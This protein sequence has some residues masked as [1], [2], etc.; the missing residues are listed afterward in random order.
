[1]WNVRIGAGDVWIGVD[2]FD[3]VHYHAYTG[4]VSSLSAA[5]FQAAAFLLNWLAIHQPLPFGRLDRRNGSLPIVQIAVIPAEIPLPEIAVKVL[6][7][8]VVVDADQSPLNQGIARFRR[9]HMN[10]TSR[11]FF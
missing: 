2:F 1:M 11:V 9:L 5:V 8:D 3:S 6:T 10:V 4:L 7:R